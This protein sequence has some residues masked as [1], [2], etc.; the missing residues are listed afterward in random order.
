MVE[1]L[2]QWM[3]WDCVELHWHGWLWICKDLHKHG[4]HWILPAWIA[5]GLGD[6]RLRGGEILQRAR[7]N[8]NWFGLGA[9]YATR[10]IRGSAHHIS[11]VGTLHCQILFCNLDWIVLHQTLLHLMKVH[12]I[13]L[14]RN[15]AIA[16]MVGVLQVVRRLRGFCGEHWPAGWLHATHCVH[17]PFVVRNPT[18]CAMR[19]GT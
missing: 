12:F 2:L 9:V 18:M 13:V 14:Q 16:S 6:I 15:A 4:L 17:L 1:A 3:H 19:N 8:F 11:I 7:L 5:L 10:C